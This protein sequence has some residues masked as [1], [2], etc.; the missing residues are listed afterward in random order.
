[1]ARSSALREWSSF[2]AI[3]WTLGLLPVDRQLRRWRGHASDA[4]T[5][6]SRRRQM[7]RPT[8]VDL[9]RR[10]RLRRVPEVGS[11]RI[12]TPLVTGLLRPVVLL[13]SG[14]LD[15]LTD[16]Q[17]QMALCHELAHLKRAD[18]WLGCVPALA[19]RV[20]FFHPLV[21]LASREYALSG[22]RPATRRSWKRWTPRRRSMDGSCCRS[23][24]RTLGQDSPLPA[25]P[26]LF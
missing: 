21:H 14:C 20:F 25:P 4:R 7:F 23:A 22:K 12:E 8:R 5:L 3:G 10:L 13:P 17:R 16:R 11:R 18:L 1:M 19:E 2:A 9:A 6:P 24:S 26:G 15:A